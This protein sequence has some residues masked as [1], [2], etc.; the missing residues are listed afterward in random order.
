MYSEAHYF[1]QPTSAARPDRKMQAVAVAYR[2]FS[3][4]VLGTEERVSIMLLQR[5]SLALLTIT[6]LVAFAP[7][8]AYAQLGAA[9]VEVDANG[10]LRTRTVA[11]PTGALTRQ[12]IA[13]ARAALNSDL[14]RPSE[15]RKVSLNR[16]EAVIAERIASGA[17]MTEDMKYLAGL[18]SI[19]YLFFYPE[20]NDIVIAGPAEG[21]MLNLA[22]RPVGVHS[23]R[24]VLQLQDLV[25]ALR[26]YAPGSNPTRKISCSID[27][28]QEGLARM[29][30]F[31]VNLGR[32]TPNDA[33]RIAAGL[34]DSLGQQVV[35]IGGIPPNT[36]FAQV[37][38]EADYRMKLIGIGLERP[39]VDIT[40]YVER[41]NPRDVARN[42]MQRWY[43]TPNYE[44]VRVSD[45]FNA[46]Q[47]VGEGVKLIGENEFVQGDGTRAAAQHVDR[48][49]QAFVTS[50]TS[51][52]AQLAERTP[53][54]AELRN[55][56]D[57]SVAA[58]FI[59]QQDWYGQSG[60]TMEVF[61]NEEIFPV[62]TY[63]VPQTV[64]SAVNVIWKGRTLM[65]PIGGGV[66]I[67]P[68]EAISVDNLLDDEEGE[69]QKLHDTINLDELEE[70]QWWWD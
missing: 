29:Q 9:G 38:V 64:E 59:Q 56:I 70:G 36:H 30:Q 22:D 6:A 53:V 24:A 21:Y 60:W 16:L 67:E 62:E 20:S 3:C 33:N 63:T 4:F 28:T 7:S 69:V 57:M 47:L 43:F 8:S 32:I 54:Y 37:L 26:A 17:G 15:L 10:V 50:F 35:T 45:D 61:G 25:V 11:D 65:T 19:D 27:P 34:R 40:S 58:A 48:A 42:A 13:Q 41:A 2:S 18:T 68:T 5:L 51:H 31:L 44:C 12:R 52:Y 49:S 14:A 55:L 46:M 23:G 1:R 39:A 66:S